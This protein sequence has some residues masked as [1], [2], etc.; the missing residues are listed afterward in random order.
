MIY[1]YIIINKFMKNYIT[2]LSAH[3][4]G[5]LLSE[6]KIDPVNLLELFIENY[7]NAPEYTK[8]A[9][10]RVLKKDALIQAELSWKRQKENRRLSFFDGIPTGWKDVIDIENYPAFGGS[11]LL[12]K[13]RKNMKVKDA[14]II[15]TAKEKGII[16]LFKTSTVEFAFGGL[17]V[18]RS[19]K[20]GKN[21]MQK[22][23]YCP[24]GSSSGSASSV[25]SNLVPIAVGTDTAG[26]IRIPSCWHGLVGFK[27]TY[28]TISIEGVIPLAK[29][30]DTVGT[31]CKNV[32]DSL[33]FYNILSEKNFIYSSLKKR[34]KIAIVNDFILPDLENKDKLIFNDFLNKLNN[35]DF[36][37][38]AIEVPEFKIVN[39]IIEEDGGLVNYEAW[40]YWKKYIKKDISMIDKNVASRFLIGKNMSDKVFY[41]TKYKINK[42]KKK[43]YTYFKNI[44]FLILP[45]LSIK[46]P[47]IKEVLDEK[48]YIFY[49]NLVLSNTRI[50][51]LFNLPAITFPVKNNYWLS[52]S[53]LGKENK[54]KDVLSISQEI[55]SINY[56]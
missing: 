22:G 41:E 39:K 40:H 18:N 35:Y 50:A 36:D 34:S 54:D 49:N 11:K 27:P 10:S 46:P 2:K 56:N 19:V 32:K 7:K 25:F 16:P 48:K 53:I 55:E 23:S 14:Q 5:T 3:E 21:Q 13:L 9:V 24:G 38:Q 8:N 4:I 1:I 47:K 45:T 26:S 33:F 15:S 52:C 31:V 29:S 12:K 43:I 42:L 17:G 37:I 44:D 51:N 6:K 20:Y 30:Y 28:N